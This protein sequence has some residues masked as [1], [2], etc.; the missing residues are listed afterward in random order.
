MKTIGPTERS[1]FRFQS[2]CSSDDT[3]LSAF[4]HR[5]YSIFFGGGLML[6]CTISIWLSCL[7]YDMN[8]KMKYSPVK[9]EHITTFYLRK[10]KIYRAMIC[11]ASCCV[12]ISSWWYWQFSL[13]FWQLQFLIAYSVWIRIWKYCKSSS[14]S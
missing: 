11:T 3:L 2:G 6:C 4:I 7:L 13:S 1:S 9:W 12:V 5:F 14:P 10:G 8:N